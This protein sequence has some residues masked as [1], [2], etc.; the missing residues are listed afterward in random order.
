MEETWESIENNERWIKGERA[1][2]KNGK[3]KT[4]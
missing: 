4:V 1:I 2:K 3:E